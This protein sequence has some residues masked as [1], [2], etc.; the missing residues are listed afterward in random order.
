MMI[1]V[2]SSRPAPGIMASRLANDSKTSSTT[3]TGTYRHSGFGN[4]SQSTKMSLQ[5]FDRKFVHSRS[6]S[7]KVTHTQLVAFGHSDYKGKQREIVEAAALGASELH[8]TGMQ[9]YTSIREGCLCAGSDRNGQG[10]TWPGS[11]LQRCSAAFPE[12]MF[13]SASCS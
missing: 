9:A 7:G 5:C 13:S 12:S 2:R 8:A 11:N 6:S 1:Q 3:V 10:E 4:G